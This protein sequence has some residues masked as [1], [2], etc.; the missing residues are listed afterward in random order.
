MKLCQ[1]NHN[2][3]VFTDEHCPLCKHINALAEKDKAIE[4][5]DHTIW[6]LEGT[7]AD[8]E[9]KLEKKE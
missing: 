3:I 1:N 2:A 5:L 4:K 6:G 7:V 8:L 9:F